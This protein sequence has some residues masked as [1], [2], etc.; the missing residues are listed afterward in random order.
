MNTATRSMDGERRVTV[1][2]DH[3]VSFDDIV[4]ILAHYAMIHMYDDDKLVPISKPYAKK[5]VRTVLVQSGRDKYSYWA[6]VFEFNTEKAD[7]IRRW[8]AREAKRNFGWM[9]VDTAL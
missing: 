9:F 1:R 4:N 7:K 2:I 6:D 3:R 8:A 5:I